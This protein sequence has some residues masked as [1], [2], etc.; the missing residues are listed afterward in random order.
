[1][2]WVLFE[3]LALCVLGRFSLRG[4][5]DIGHQKSKTE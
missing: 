4:V 3:R 2:G 5:K 1:L